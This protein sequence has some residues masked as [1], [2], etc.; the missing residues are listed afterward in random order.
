MN[1]K[2]IK[3]IICYLFIHLTSNAQNIEGRVLEV[4]DKNTILPI[5]NA[6]V[7]WEGTNISAVS[8][9]DGYYVIG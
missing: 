3:F 5:F 6:N 7:Y 9:E 8:N 2:T 4:I 1:I